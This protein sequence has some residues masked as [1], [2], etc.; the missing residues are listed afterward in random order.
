MMN[1]DKAAALA[2]IK[3]KEVHFTWDRYEDKDII[4]PKLAMY[5]EYV[6]RDHKWNMSKSIVF[7]I[8][9]FNTSIEQD[10]ERIYTLRELGYL[11][12]VMIYDK[13]HCDPV[14]KKMQRWVNNRF[15]FKKCLK[16][17]DYQC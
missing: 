14:Y 7:T 6:E 3:M 15:I 5:R 4:L 9:N 8:V 12:Y 2:K 11:A 10:L 13:E 16:F 1:E 17:E